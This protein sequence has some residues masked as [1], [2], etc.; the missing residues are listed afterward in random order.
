MIYLKKKKQNTIVEFN[1]IQMHT[2]SNL[3]KSEREIIPKNYV[4]KFREDIA[5]DLFLSHFSERIDSQPK[6]S[7]DGNFFS[8]D[9]YMK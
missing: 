3:N 6:N 2:I 8:I 4:N 7:S 1:P 9:I 5:S